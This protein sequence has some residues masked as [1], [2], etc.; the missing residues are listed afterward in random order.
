M[1]LGKDR[2]ATNEQQLLP[3][4][5]RG[6]EEEKKADEQE[7]EEYDEEEEEELEDEEPPL[8]TLPNKAK[9]P[10]APPVNNKAMASSI[11]SNEV[12][13]K[14]AED[15]TKKAVDSKLASKQLSK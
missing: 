7:D 4:R 14:M 5:N 9:Q 13:K 10:Q 8:D 11:M 3:N 6:L 12:M 2:L 1:L 15:I